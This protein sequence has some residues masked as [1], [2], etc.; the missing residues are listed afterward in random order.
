MS[1]TSEAFHNVW[2]DLAKLALPESVKHS[3]DVAK[4]GRDLLNDAVKAR[5]E[6]SLP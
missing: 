3:V 4:L 2:M 5:I 1:S 6:A